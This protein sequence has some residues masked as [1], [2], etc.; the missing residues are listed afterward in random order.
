MIRRLLRWAPSATD[1]ITDG[2][3]SCAP[4]ITAAR[5]IACPPSPAWITGGTP[6]DFTRSADRVAC[7]AHK[8]RILANLAVEIDS[9]L[10][11]ADASLGLSEH[12]TKGHD[13]RES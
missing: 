1:S 5:R 8:A 9:P 2:L 4:R 7:G 10:A 3:L 13:R 12:E 6:A 11:R